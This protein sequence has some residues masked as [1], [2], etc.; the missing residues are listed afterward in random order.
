MS[1]V[2]CIA[3]GFF[4]HWGFS[5]SSDSKLSACNVGELGLNPGSEDPLVKEM[6]IHSPL[7]NSMDGVAW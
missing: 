5:G 3:G 2:S 7:E 6:A 1:I 4:T